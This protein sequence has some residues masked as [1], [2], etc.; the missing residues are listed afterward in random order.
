MI[1][2]RKEVQS[3]LSS[4]T[5]M[6]KNCFCY[7]KLFFFLIIS[8]NSELYSLD[9]ILEYFPLSS[10]EFIHQLPDIR[11][12]FLVQC[13]PFKMLLMPVLLVRKTAQN[14]QSR[15]LPV[16]LK[17]NKILIRVYNR[18]LESLP[19]G[20]TIALGHNVI[21]YAVRIFDIFLFSWGE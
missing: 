19:E 12:A 9:N 5:T 1:M 15:F 7:I 17:L 4:I 16:K 21:I 8:F 14:K 13:C 10:D 3:L 2:I 18:W 11:T 20:T 6:Q